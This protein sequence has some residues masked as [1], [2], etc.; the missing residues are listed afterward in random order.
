MVH[1][2]STLDSEIKIF[3]IGRLDEDEIAA[4]WSDNSAADQEKLP[5]KANHR[6]TLLV[7]LTLFHS[8]AFSFTNVLITLKALLPSYMLHFFL[9]QFCLWRRCH[10]TV[11]SDSITLKSINSEEA[12]QCELISHLK[13]SSL[14]IICHRVNCRSTLP[15]KTAI[16]WALS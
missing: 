14:A 12:P 2:S 10:M 9:L 5:T 3:Y 4:G 15:V 13:S 16:C 11:L 8:S 1:L 7:A 6:S